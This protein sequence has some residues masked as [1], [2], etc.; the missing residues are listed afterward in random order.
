MNLAEHQLL[1]P[2]F[3]SPLYKTV[4]NSTELFTVGKVGFEPG[5]LA[6]P[7]TAKLKLLAE[8]IM[9]SSSVKCLFEVNEYK[10]QWLTK[11]HS[12]VPVI[13]ISSK[14]VSVEKRCKKP[15]WPDRK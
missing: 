5:E 3:L 12:T 14:H 2:Q 8:N 13:R 15:D 6:L 1:C 7:Q 4:F 11:I 10:T 9:I